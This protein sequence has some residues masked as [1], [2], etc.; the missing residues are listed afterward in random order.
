MSKSTSPLIS[1]CLPVYETEPYLEACLRSV[2]TQDFDSFEILVL[3]DASFG[4]DER[5]RSTKKIVR[6]ME[7]ECKKVRKL[8]GLAPVE[9]HY[10][11]HSE[12]RGLVEVRRTLVYEAHGKYILQC[13]SDDQLEAGALKAL[14]KA[15]S[16]GS[17][18]ANSGS[19][20][21][22]S[23][24][25]AAADCDIVHGTSTAGTF[26]SENIFTSAKENR[27]GAIHYGKL[28]GREIFTRWL[29]GKEVAGTSWGK[30]ISREL[31]LKAFENIPYTECNMAEDF[32]LFFYISLNAKSYTGIE[33]KVYRYRLNSGMTGTRKISTPLAWRK[34]CSAASVFA[35]IS[36]YMQSKPE[37][38][39][40][41]EVEE[42]RRRTVFYLNNNLKQLRE[43]VVPEIQDKAY[44]M[45]CEYWGTDFVERVEG[46]C[47]AE[48]R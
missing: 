43:T 45:L 3:N 6:A 11:E 20:T 14:A 36:Q 10:I 34:I 12:N 28:E 19:T 48:P 22:N 7:K 29:L 16:T 44:A 47:G 9:L 27:Y 17:T 5:G 33:T 25:A 32:L 37:S 23:G 2:I 41:E 21:A 4:R 31:F 1:V 18:T 26:D 39:S 30:L 42:V 38:F 35:I 8:S 40:N 15:V 46:R 13:D 24:S